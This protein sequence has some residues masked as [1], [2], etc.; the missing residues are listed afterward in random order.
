MPYL[1]EVCPAV[2]PRSRW[3]SAA[4]A[5][6]SCA[7]FPQYWAPRQRPRR[8]WP[9]SRSRTERW[10]PSVRGKNHSGSSQAAEWWRSPPALPTGSARGWALKDAGLRTSL[11]RCVPRCPICQRPTWQRQPCTGRNQPGGRGRPDGSREQ[12]SQRWWEWWP[13]RRWRTASPWAAAAPGKTRLSWASQHTF[14]R[15]LGSPGER[16]QVMDH[17]LL[18]HQATG[19]PLTSAGASER[20]LGRIRAP[21]GTKFRLR[22][23][24]MRIAPRQVYF[25]TRSWNRGLK[26]KEES[27]TLDRETPSARVR[28]RV[29]W[30]ITV[31][32]M[33]VN[34]SPQPKPGGEKKN[35]KQPGVTSLFWAG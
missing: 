1:T 9:Q 2:P 4:P 14:A 7:P 6:P 25:S 18:N 11:R 10:S 16:K 19:A 29:K 34:T 27:P 33:G 30:A 17:K 22:P 20:R 3:A 28:C 24:R 26:A 35:N 8:S 12:S 32:S 31:A 21:Q 13:S 5:H 15:F 23:P